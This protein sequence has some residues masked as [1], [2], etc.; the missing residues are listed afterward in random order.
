[1]CLINYFYNEDMI[2]I[3]YEK[4]LIIFQHVTQFTYCLNHANHFHFNK[5]I[6]FLSL[7][8]QFVKKSIN[9]IKF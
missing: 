6:I 5:S 3:N 1:M 7:C 9:Y 8:K 2:S 4:A